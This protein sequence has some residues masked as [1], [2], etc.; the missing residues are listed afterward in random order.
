MFIKSLF[1][2]NPSS[3]ILVKK[4]KESKIP[5]LIIILLVL[6]KSFY[7]KLLLYLILNNNN[8]N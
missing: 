1:N 6:D 2:K 5:T 3:N 7:L 8:K 4:D